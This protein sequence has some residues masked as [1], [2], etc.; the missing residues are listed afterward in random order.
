MFI[1][2]SLSMCEKKATQSHV[3]LTVFVTSETIPLSEISY[4]HLSWP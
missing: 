1:F 3:G 4:S 2:I